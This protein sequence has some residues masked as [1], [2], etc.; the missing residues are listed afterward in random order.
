[1]SDSVNYAT[2]IA[3]PQASSATN[4]QVNTYSTP[5][6]CGACCPKSRRPPRSMVSVVSSEK[7]TNSNFLKSPFLHNGSDRNTT[8]AAAPSSAA[9]VFVLVAE[10]LYWS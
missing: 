3:Q 5:V 10:F 1:M 4:E 8:A 6:A 7:D 9:L 2:R